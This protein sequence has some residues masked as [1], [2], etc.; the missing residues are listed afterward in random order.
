MAT[1]EP[2]KSFVETI[3]E[4]TAAGKIAWED[5]AT[6]GQF[7]ASTRSG[8][9]QVWDW[10]G[11]YPDDSGY[12]LTVLN[13]EGKIVESISKGGGPEVVHLRRIWEGARRIARN[14]DDVMRKMLEDLQR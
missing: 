10:T 9:L 2:L 11:D 8:S 13:R 12:A 14:A 6:D 3:A 5:G 7:I 4:L 1:V